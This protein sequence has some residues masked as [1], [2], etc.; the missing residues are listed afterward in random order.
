M[1]AP[2]DQVDPPSDVPVKAKVTGVQ[3]KSETKVKLH[4]D[5][6]GGCRKVSQRSLW[7][8]W[9]CPHMIDALLHDPDMYWDTETGQMTPRVKV[10]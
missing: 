8:E 7:H 5:C 2:G 1:Y 4:G 3:V 9:P 10:N 6:V